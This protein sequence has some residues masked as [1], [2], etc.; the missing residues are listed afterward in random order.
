MFSLPPGYRWRVAND[1]EF[2]TVELQKRWVLF[3]LMADYEPVSMIVARVYGEAAAV[4]T[5]KSRILSR[6]TT[7]RFR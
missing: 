5:A 4:R 1:G 3:W 6:N 2:V 7:L